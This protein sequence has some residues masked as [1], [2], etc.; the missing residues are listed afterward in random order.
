M[1]VAR[2]RLEVA[3]RRGTPNF[4]F[5]GKFRK[6]RVRCVPLASVWAAARYESDLSMEFFLVALSRARGE[7]LS[8]REPHFGLIKVRQRGAIK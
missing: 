5:A 4:S 2:P 7:G 8:R 6:T 1:V 3:R